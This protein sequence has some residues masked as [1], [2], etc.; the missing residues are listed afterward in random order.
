[1]ADD[2][3]SAGKSTAVLCVLGLFCVLGVRSVIR[4]RQYKQTNDCHEYEDDVSRS[5]IVEAPSADLAKACILL[6]ATAG[7][8]LS[9]V[10]SIVPTTRGKRGLG[11]NEWLLFGA[12]VRRRMN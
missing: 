5:Q 4:E 3:G 2:P 1:M 10:T 8:A 7:M 11:S 9:L 12:W 6:F